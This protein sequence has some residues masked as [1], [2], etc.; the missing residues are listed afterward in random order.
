MPETIVSLDQGSGTA[1]SRR[2]VGHIANV[3]GDIYTGAMED[4]A[5]VDT[6]SARIALTTDSFVVDPMF[7]GGGDIGKI[8]ICG[9]V[10]DLAVSGA[11]PIAIT[12]ALIL[13]EG[14]PYPVLT[15]VLE[16]IRATAS[17]A[18]VKIVAGDTKVVRKGETDQMFINT[19]GVGVFE[20]E[21]LRMA[22]VRSGD[23]IILT[24]Q[25]GNHAI[26]LL[27]MREGLGFESRVVSD[28]A[29]LSGMLEDVLR[30]APPKSVRSIRDATRGGFAAV[31]HEYSAAIDQKILFDYS[32]LPIQHETAMAGDML[33]IDP[34]H[35]A[36]E[37]CAVIFASPDV[38]DAV[39][40]RLRGHQYG[41][42]ACVVGEVTKDHGCEVRMRDLTGDVRILEEL[43]GTPLPRLC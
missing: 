16:S 25:I 39:C 31:M 7:F 30:T 37:G 13:E 8:A 36:N 27:S 28:C 14:L 21:P 20:R 32:A 43:E 33:G 24:G 38:A 5:I 2:L 3:L 23:K 34:I 41:R 12:L 4:S 26:H 17:D 10:N 19:T 11:R 29:P 22:D 35:L 9:T 6:G 18:G 42:N 1:A 40:D 15:R